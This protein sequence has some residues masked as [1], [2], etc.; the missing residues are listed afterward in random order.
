MKLVKK[1]FALLIIV[2]L[3][4]SVTFAKEKTETTAH[5]NE[6]ICNLLLKLG[7]I[8]DSFAFQ[9]GEPVKRQEFAQV[10]EKVGGYDSANEPY[11]GYYTDVE[12]GNEYAQSIELLT[13]LG[14]C[15]GFDG[16]F[17]PKDNVT[18]EQAVTM[19][20]KVAGYD[21]LAKTYGGGY[22]QSYLRA[23]RNQGLTK[24]VS[25]AFGEIT[26]EDMLVLVYNTLNLNTLNDYSKQGK[27]TIN[28]N[29]T[30]LTKIHHI[31]SIQ[32]DVITNGVSGYLS[33]SDISKD[34][35]RIENK[36]ETVVLHCG[37]TTIA[38]ELGRNVI[39]Y[40]NFDE[41]KDEGTVVYYEVS[42]KNKE[43]E[44]SFRDLDSFSN[45]LVEYEENN[46]TKKE[47][48]NNPIIIYNNSY[49][50]GEYPT[51][52]ELK[53]LQGNMLLIDNNGDGK[54]EI[55]NIK[56]YKTYVVKYYQSEDMKIYPKEV[57]IGDEQDDPNDV[58]DEKNGVDVDFD[59]YDMSELIFDDGSPAVFEDIVANAIISVAKS[60]PDSQAKTIS[61][62]ISKNKASGI[63]TGVTTDD[64]GNTF[65]TIDG[66]DEYKVLKVF[67]NNKSFPDNGAG[68][69][70][71][72]DAF[73]NVADV[74]TAYMGEYSYGLVMKIHKD[75]VHNKAMVKLYCSD[76]TLE[77][78]NLADK[79]K[80]EGVTYRTY[81]SAYDALKNIVDNQ[82]IKAP[83]GTDDLT[84]Y[85]CRYKLNEDGEVK[86]LD[87]AIE[88]DQKQDDK[89]T[90]TTYWRSGNGDIKRAKYSNDGTLGFLPV[91]S[92]TK[93]IVL[94]YYDMND[95]ANL[96]EDDITGGGTNNLSNN[97]RYTYIA[98]RV[99]QKT[100]Y[101]DLVIRF[102]GKSD[103]PS[104]TVFWLTVKGM[105]QV[106]DDEECEAR[107]AVKGIQ[108]G[109]EVMMIIDP[110]YYEE[111]SDMGLQRGDVIQCATTDGY[112]VGC[113][114]I[115]KH[116]GAGNDKTIKIK[117]MVDP[118]GNVKSNDYHDIIGV[119]TNTYMLNGRVVYREE[120]LL[121]FATLSNDP[122]Y[123]TTKDYQKEEATY[124]MHETIA[125]HKDFYK[126]N[127][128]SDGTIEVTKTPLDFV[129]VGES[130]PV[131]VYDAETDRVYIGTYDDIK[132]NAYH[133]SIVVLRFESSQVKEV[134]VLNEG[135]RSDSAN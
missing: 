43:K 76:D 118:T 46:K 30:V 40:Y 82:K 122:A 83:N 93:V 5:N 111:I 36:D 92:Q 50:T 85:P 57:M 39:V 42:K 62:I 128:K 19:L 58:D 63:L 131:T 103:D 11:H 90:L 65:V 79:V 135:M 94:N 72:L 77:M 69:T 47:K 132:S 20:L 10:V 87:F 64:N 33:R 22:P 59:N 12:E 113:R 115:V 26:G 84:I 80:I 15:G 6:E 124:T 49:F 67:T 127:V 130:V 32:G 91:S 117:N 18:L 14:I 31:Y 68:I 81:E 88:K 74:A 2:S 3:L 7:F 1:I 66:E 107:W 61:V 75:S 4:P 9:Y 129:P 102:S 38:D 99:N 24:D 70:L 97:S 73:G 48:I 53:N 45:T 44:I 105:Q 112:L 116:S 17:N 71:Y 35:V 60:R 114:T 78:H 56:A 23:A 8:D 110:Y 51:V 104:S 34:C 133:E 55:I 16:N 41:V 98:F 28:K 86:D 106:W 96:T 29:E 100:P 120:G 95:L 125:R 109:E 126:E 25:T 121:G 89:D 108:N 27:I 123:T 21:E 119:K 101:V 13:T 37:E 134:V 54:Y 52:D